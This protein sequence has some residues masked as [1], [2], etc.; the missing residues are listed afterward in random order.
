[1][2]L[3]DPRR[4]FDRVYAG[5]GRVQRALQFLEFIEAQEPVITEATTMLFGYRNRIRRVKQRLIGFG[6]AVLVVGALLYVVL[7]FPD[8]TR[9]MLPKGVDYTWFQ[10]G[11]L[12][13]L[14][15]L[16]VN[17]IRNMRSMGGPGD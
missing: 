11:L 5:T 14:L 2:A 12:A 6:T 3:L 7:V 4:T 10:L 16:I 8:N 15:V 17:L 13:V 1:M 9:Q